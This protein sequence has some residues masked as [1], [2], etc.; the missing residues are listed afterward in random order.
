MNRILLLSILLFAGC[1]DH[2]TDVSNTLPEL[3]IQDIIREAVFRYQFQHNASGQ[4]QTAKIFFLSVIILDDSTGY[5]TNSNPSLD[6]LR[7]FNNNVPPVKSFSE[8]TLS[9]NGV[10]DIKTGE[11]GLLFQIGDIRWISEEQVEVD[12]GYFE[13]GLSASGNTYYVERKNGQ[14]IVMRDVMHWIS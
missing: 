9:V 12:G 5:R 4:Q 3:S 11:S 8:C 1:A 10:F 14:W 2:G 7:H 6:I 13:A